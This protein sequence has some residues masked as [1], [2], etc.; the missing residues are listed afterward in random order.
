M[1]S[2]MYLPEVGHKLLLIL[3]YWG[4]PYIEIDQIKVKVELYTNFKLFLSWN[5][6]D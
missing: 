3:F 4:E 6:S 2:I 5:W 1:Q